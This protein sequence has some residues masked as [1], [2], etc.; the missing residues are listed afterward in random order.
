SSIISRTYY[1]NMVTHLL[2][3]KYQREVYRK[4]DE[5]EALTAPLLNEIKKKVIS[6]IW[7]DE[8]EIT[9]G[10]ELSW[11][12]KPHYYMRLYQYTYYAGLTIGTVMSKRIKNEVKPDV[13][14]WLNVLKSGGSKSPD[15]LTDIN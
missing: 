10:A 11:M 3:A 7:G 9:D 15:E 4:V 2:E 1:H 12:N 13:D 6:D 8:D 5:G 14:D